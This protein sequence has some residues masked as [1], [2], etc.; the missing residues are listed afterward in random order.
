MASTVVGEAEVGGQVSRGAREG[1]HCV[2][3]VADRLGVGR[4]LELV[5]ER[6]CEG[7]KGAARKLL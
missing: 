1:E 6:V 3:D 5:L 4:L 7:E 2:H